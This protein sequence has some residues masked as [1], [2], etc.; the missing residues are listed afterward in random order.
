[1]EHRAKKGFIEG[2]QRYK[3][4]KPEHEI[5]TAQAGKNS[6]IP[7]T[8]FT[9]AIVLP[10]WRGSILAVNLRLMPKFYP[11]FSLY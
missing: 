5:L 9:I 10:A 8:K 4:R 6:N 2:V 11:T 3:I 1:V 7:Y